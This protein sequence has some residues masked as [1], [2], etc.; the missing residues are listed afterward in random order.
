[1][2]VQILWGPLHN[3]DNG[4]VNS[5]SQCVCGGCGKTGGVGGEEGK[6]WDLRWNFFL[7][8]AETVLR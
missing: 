3:P 5:Y 6:M 4:N 1:M 2:H 8:R 7:T